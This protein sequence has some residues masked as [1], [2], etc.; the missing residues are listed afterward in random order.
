MP[1]HFHLL[2]G[3]QSKEVLVREAKNLIGLVEQPFSNFF[4]SYA[5]SFNR[6]YHRKGSLF[7]RPFKR[8]KISSDD[9][10]TKIVHYIH[11][12]PVHHGFVKKVEDWPYS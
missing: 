12:N 5:K 10:L 4:N 2:V 8:K 7:N 3:K 1:S 11:Y 6:K 9:Y